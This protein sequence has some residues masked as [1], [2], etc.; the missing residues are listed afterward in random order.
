MSPKGKIYV[1]IV[2]IEGQTLK[3]GKLGVFNFEGCYAYV[4]SDQKGGRLARHARKGKP[5]KWHID[6]LTEKAEVLGA[7]T[8]PLPQENESE[9]AKHLA[10]F[11]PVVAGFGSSDCKDGGHLFKAEEGLEKVVAGFADN[12]GVAYKWWGQ[13]SKNCRL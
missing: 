6:Y 1:L 5:L 11:F 13:N 8:L 9:L 4:G 2:K 3:I 12:K 7:W 10:K